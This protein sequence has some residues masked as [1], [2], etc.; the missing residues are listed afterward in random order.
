MGKSLWSVAEP[1]LLSQFDPGVVGVAWVDDKGRFLHTWGLADSIAQKPCAHLA[2]FVRSCFARRHPG[3][4]RFDDLRFFCAPQTGDGPPGALL[5][6][7]TAKEEAAADRRAVQSQRKADALEKIG[8]ALT[9]HQTLQPLAVAATHAIATAAELAAT[10]LWVRSS[11]EGPL[12]LLASVGASR[13]GTVSLHCLRPDDGVSCV[14]ELAV[15]SGRNLVVANVKEHPMTS[16]VEGKFC[17]LAPGGMILLP[18]IIQGNVLGLLEVIGREEDKHFLDYQDLFATVAE[19]LSLAL[20]SALM[21]ENLERLAAYDPLTGIANHRTMQEFLHRRLSEASRSDGRVGVIMLDVDHFRAFNEEEG[22]DAGDRVLKMVSDVLRTIVRPYDLAARYGGEEFT[23]V[24]PGV[25]AGRTYQI[26]ERIRTGIESLEYT[27]YTG[28]PRRVTASLGC[29][30]FPEN[31]SDAASLIKAADLAL[32]EAKRT[33]RNRTV[34][35]EGKCKSGE[36]RSVL[37]VVR[38]LI[39]AELHDLTEKFLGS[40]RPHFACLVEELGLST[41][42]AQTLE[43][44]ALLSPYW[45]SLKR[46]QEREEMD[47]ITDRE[48]LRHVVACFAEWE[49]RFDGDGPKHLAGEAIPLLTRILIVVEAL[50]SS[51][52]QTFTSDP[53]RYDLS[54]VNL[55]AEKESAA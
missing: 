33:T 19:H 23:I 24:M 48:S 37:S 32:Y 2:R 14:A 31:A 52:G 49:E 6:M 1:P 47:S 11:E 21:Y 54:L 42:Q 53:G 39:P 8:K 36:N 38:S 25:D 3:I 55:L 28:E 9:S 26:A 16:D 13:A 51:R 5:L 40:C 43:A 18:L 46:R 20:N 12:E 22:H 50:V 17:Y 15:G 7:V 34:L 27:S 10:L 45:A 35:Y 4:Q 29:A 41:V 30:V 44:A